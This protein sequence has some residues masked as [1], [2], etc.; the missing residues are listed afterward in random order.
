MMVKN[1]YTL[2]DFHRMRKLLF[3]TAGVPLSSKDRST[4]GG[5]KEVRRLGLD[6][7]EIEFV[8]GV[9]MSVELAREVG[10]VAK[11]SE[12]TLTA[13]APYYINLLSSEEEKLRASIQRIIDTARIT[14]EACGYSVT[15]HAA[16]Y[17]KL[18]REEA[19]RSVKRSLSEI[20]DTLRGEDIKIWIR[21][22]TTGKGTQFGTLSEILNLS[23]EIENVLPCIDF[24]HIHAR[25]VGKF[26]SYEEFC[27]ILEELEDRVGR[28]ALDNMHIHFS[29]IDYG[30]KGEKK[31][32]NLEE[33][34]FDY[35]GLLRALKDF[36]VRGVAISESPNIEGDA[37]LMKKIWESL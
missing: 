25:S 11:E 17:G 16:Y 9:K 14:H 30:E 2:S 34:D 7:M 33:S 1:L 19:Y 23:E 36:D 32:L 5:V 10:K 12:V 13:H 29:G 37:L 6:A 20:V 27:S 15:F 26:N 28:E 22:E 31:H 18:S 3:G 24:A 4:L 35:K 8:R 21:P